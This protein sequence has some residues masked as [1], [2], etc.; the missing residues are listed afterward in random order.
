MKILFFDMEFA[1]GRVPGSIYSLGYLITDE[2][3][4]PLCERTDL[5]LN[6]D[7]SWNEYVEANILA[8]PK[9][10]VEASPKF[11][12]RY[13]EIKALFQSVDLA[14]GFAVGNDTRALRAACVRYGLEPIAF[15]YFDTEKLCKK[16]EDHKDARGLGGCVQAWCGEEPDHRHRSD[17]D[18]YA[19]M[20]LMR[21]ICKAKHVTP[22]MLLLAFPECA[23]HTVRP[24][25]TSSRKPKQKRVKKR[26]SKQNTDQNNKRVE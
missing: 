11:F 17:G 5:L 24:S 7:S 4:S 15:P 3:F 16:I 12:E 26:P 14:V 18:A 13:E 8:Y 25:R 2:T 19:T 23:G 20:M 1:D 10:T 9:E 22:Q 21:A 6:P